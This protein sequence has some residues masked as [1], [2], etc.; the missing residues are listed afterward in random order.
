MA[1]NSDTLY[2]VLS[3]IKA[4]PDKVIV[5]PGQYD[6]AIVMYLDDDVKLGNPEIYFPLHKLMVNRMAPEFM[7]MNNELLDYFHDQTR[8]KD[9]SYHELWITTSHLAKRNKFLVD[10]SFE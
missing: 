7:S 6:N 8:V 1:S 4:H 10:L 5:E 9:S 2:H 3:Y